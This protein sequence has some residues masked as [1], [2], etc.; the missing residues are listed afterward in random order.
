MTDVTGRT[1]LIAGA[2]SSAGRAVARALVAAGAQVVSVGSNA[3]RLA[4]LE[5]DVPRI[6][7]EQCDLTDESDVAELALRV[8]AQVGHL[9]GLVHLVGGWRGGGGI[10][11]QTEDDFRFLEGSLTALRHE[12]R[13]FVDDLAASEAGR[14]LIVSSTS[15]ARPT[16][17][18]AN[19]TAVKAASE[20]WTLAV[21]Q[22]FSANESGDAAAAIVRVR[23]L[24]GL[25]DALAEHVVGLWSTPAADVNGRIATL[26]A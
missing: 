20:A 18:N 24:D 10:A 15:V 6:L 3:E 23:A 25:E 1:V 12:T 7:T 14:L 26:S 13:F 8:R 17:S 2:T 22:G 4:E 5:A 16:A 21:A 19:Y 11:G 9:D